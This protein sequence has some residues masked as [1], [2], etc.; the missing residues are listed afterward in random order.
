[1]Y[2]IIVLHLHCLASTATLWLKCIRAI[3]ALHIYCRVIPHYLW[4]EM[5]SSSKSAPQPPAGAPPLKLILKRKRDVEW[6]EWAATYNP[7]E[8]T[9]A[10]AA[11]AAQNHA[12]ADLLMK[13]ITEDGGIAMGELLKLQQMLNAE[14]EQRLAADL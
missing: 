9:A 8:D 2:K 6:A 10:A 7:D 1:M 5:A 13:V 12:S 3:P 14:V 4:I 11:A